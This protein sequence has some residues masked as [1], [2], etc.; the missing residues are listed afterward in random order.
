MQT[1]TKALK[2]MLIVSIVFASSHTQAHDYSFLKLLKVGQCVQPYYDEYMK[3]IYPVKFELI[4]CDSNWLGL[5]K[6]TN[7]GIDYIV[8]DNKVII[9]AQSIAG[10]SLGK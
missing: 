7:I 6:I 3:I 2:I 10:I 8:F 5:R 1:Y 9:T 4:P